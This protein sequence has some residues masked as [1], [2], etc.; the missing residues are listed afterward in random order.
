[1]RVYQHKSNK[2]NYLI[3]FSITSTTYISIVD[4]YIELIKKNYPLILLDRY[5][6]EIEWK[7]LGELKNKLTDYFNSS[8]VK[9]LN[10]AAVF[11]EALEAIN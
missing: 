4:N 11:K 9:A 5:Y 3:I 1:M 8:Y 7:D 2:S 6:L 10:K